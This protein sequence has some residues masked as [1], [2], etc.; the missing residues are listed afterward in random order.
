MTPEEYKK[1]REAI[2]TQQ[3]AAEFLGVTRQ[4]ISA[5]EKDSARITKEAAI[6]IRELARTT[7]K[8][9]RSEGYERRSDAS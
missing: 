6:A 5:R 7:K 8:N 3:D 2:G 9:A 1:L 4:L